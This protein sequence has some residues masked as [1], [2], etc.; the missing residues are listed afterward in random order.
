MTLIA[1]QSM[2]RNTTYWTNQ[3]GKS[4]KIHQDIQGCLIRALKCSRLHPV[5]ELFG[6]SIVL[7]PQ[8]ITRMP[9]GLTRKM[10]TPSGYKQLILNLTKSRSINSRIWD[11]HPGITPNSRMLPRTIR[12]SKSSLCSLSNMMDITRQDLLEVETSSETQVRQF[13]QK[14]YPSGASG[15]QCYC[16]NSN[17][18]NYWGS[19]TIW[20][21]LQLTGFYPSP[22]I[23]RFLY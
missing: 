23:L 22:K 14:L 10:E 6:I 20:L 16:Q 4:Q 9:S 19:G 15:W 11:L 18:L 2:A 13:T 17:Q 1:V 8:E 12:R 21:L 5:R 3:V 7:K